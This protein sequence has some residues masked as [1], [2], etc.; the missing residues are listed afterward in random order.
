MEEVCC[1]SWKYEF[2]SELY[3][4]AVGHSRQIYPIV[5]PCQIESGL[6][7]MQWHPKTR[8]RRNVNTKMLIKR[9]SRIGWG[10]LSWPEVGSQWR[11]LKIYFVVYS[12]NFHQTV[13]LL[14]LLMMMRRSRVGASV[15]AWGGRFTVAIQQYAAA[16][17]STVRWAASQ[18][19]LY[20]N[21]YRKL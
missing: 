6:F 7:D 17:A 15:V 12:C 13:L 5:S 2:N 4:S 19:G 10:P 1:I 14:L 11:F 8:G 18:P 20:Q 3:S 9:R 16:A 21:P